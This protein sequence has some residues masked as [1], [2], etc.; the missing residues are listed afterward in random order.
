MKTNRLASL[1][2]TALFAIPLPTSRAEQT[3]KPNIIILYADDLGYGDLACYN[4][5]SPIPTPNLDALASQGMR[6]TDAHSSSGI[7]TPSRYAMLTGRHHWRDFHNI[8]NSFEPSVFPKGRLTMAGML[9]SEGYRTA[10]MGKWHLG[11]N[12]DAI[13]KNNAPAQK[14]GGKK[15]KAVGVEDYD[16][17]KPIPGGPLS[18]GFDHYFGEDVINFPPYCWFVDDKIIQAPDRMLKSWI[19]EPVKEGK[20]QLRPGPMAPDW[21]PYEVVPKLTRHAVEFIKSRKNEEQPFFL[22][23]AYPS[24]HTPIIPNKEFVGKSGAGPYGDYVV[25]TDDSVGQI[26][27]ALKDSGL[28]D[29]TLVVFTADN[30]PEHYAYERDEKFGHWSS[31]PFRGLKRDIYEG[32]HRLPFLVKWPGVVPPGSVCNALVSQID[33][34]ATFAA[35]VGYKLPA[36]AAEDSHDLLPLF[37]GGTGAVRDTHVHN[38]FDT[39]AIRHG[40]W[41]LVDAK[42]G[43]GSKVDP[44][45]ETRH[46]YP[47]DDS[48]AAELYNIKEDI[49][50][51]KN[52][53]AA[54]PEKVEELRSLLNKIRQQGHT[55]PRLEGGPQVKEEPYRE[56]DGQTLSR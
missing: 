2:A 40:D 6:F 43:Y 42:D 39:F 31:H 50:Q 47:A 19:W 9:H 26:L 53:A 14:G 56:V 41:V 25:E 48:E 4:P 1:L 49:A 45:W 24:P 34:M 10:A 55:A 30:G 11:W 35:V 46:G 38:T 20:P 36:N 17:L 3:A 15:K 27:A 18:V 23:F 44:E 22:Y 37:Q 33:L 13:K 16:W 29:K 51:K 7:C 21:N 5:K 12:W 52:L 54:H 8:V 28:D 32:G